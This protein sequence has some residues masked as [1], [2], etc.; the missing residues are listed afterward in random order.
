MALFS[1]GIMLTQNKEPALSAPLVNFTNPHPEYIREHKDINTNLNEIT[2]KD[3]IEL[4]KLARIYDERDGRLL[5]SKLRRA[6]DK[7]QVI[8]VDAIDDEPY[9]SR[10]T[11][12]MLQLGQELIIGIELA[13]KVAGT[14][15]VVI[16]TY[17]NMGAINSAI[18]STIGGYKVEKIAGGYPALPSFSA[19]RDEGREE[20]MVV[21]VGALIHLARAI[22]KGMPQ[23]TTFVTVAGN[24][25]AHPMNM[26]VS[27]GMNL[28]A[29]LERCGMIAQPTRVITGGS[30]TGISIVDTDK[31]VITHTTGSILA[32]HG[33]SYERAYSCIGCGR[34]EQ[35]CPAGLNPMY[36][37]QIMNRK[38]YS[39]LE[40][41]DPQHCIECG[42]C[43]YMCPSRLN[44]SGMAIR[45]KKYAL[46]HFEKPEKGDENAAKK[47]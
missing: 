23:T 24:S 27:L 28:T 21:G 9:I 3:I 44:V 37:L 18:P 13:S 12:P 45:A 30:M 20:S 10:K 42:T 4:A 16:K 14:D 25:I 41:F 1:K 35:N 36:I 34:C 17:R 6:R 31:T 40:V 32:F 29:I 2:T 7:A 43:S 46:E 5:V 19:V 26:E 47:E 15:N 38:A 8:Y 11:A 22:T 33:K 39:Q